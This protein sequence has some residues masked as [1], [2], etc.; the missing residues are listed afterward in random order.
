[1]SDPIRVLVVDDSVVIRRLLSNVIDGDP[2][3]DVVG[4]AQNGEIALKRI[5][6]LEPD[7]V[8]LDIEMPELDGLGALEQLRVDHPKLPVV[9]FSTLTERGASATMR[10]LELGASDYVTKPANVGSVQ[11][12]MDRVRADLVPKLKAL[13]RP[14]SVSTFAPLER[15]VQT[16]APTGVVDVIA[17]GSSTG[18]P[19]ALS[20][21]IAAFPQELPVPVVIVQHMPPL[22]TNF[23]AKRLDDSCAISVHEGEPGMVLEAGH[24]YIAPGD[25][26]MTVHHSAFGV[27]LATD[28]AEP[29]HFC[30]PA[31]DALFRSVASV[32]G[33]NV[34]AAI[35]TGMGSDGRDG[36]VPLKEAGAHII[37]QNEATSVV[38]G[39]P[40]AVVSAGLADQVE[41]LQDI[42]P[43][44]ARRAL[45]RQSTAAG[46]RS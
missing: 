35:L 12:A 45:S 6:Q 24:A 43:A 2:D 33:G 19:N 11:V 37:A 16:C 4:I 41:P 36:C 5:K 21:V 31:V 3:L 28:Q 44:L 9:M 18:G 8:T 42:G 23:L 34:V 26:H 25:F 14:A 20:D 22:F 46:S 17:I 27:T 39:M 30:R 15:P 32:Y 29:E 10:A 1:M 7:I 40:G 38:W 13:C